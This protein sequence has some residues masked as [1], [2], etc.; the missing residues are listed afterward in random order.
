MLGFGSWLTGFLWVCNLQISNKSVPQT[1]NRI[2]RSLSSTRIEFQSCIEIACSLALNSYCLPLVFSFSDSLLTFLSPRVF[3]TQMNKKPS[4]HDESLIFLFLMFTVD[5]Q[6]SAV[7]EV[8]GNICYWRCVNFA[9]S[10]SL[11]SVGRTPSL[12]LAISLD[13][14]ILRVW[15]LF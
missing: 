3:F 6:N 10:L 4:L 5:C 14:D 9:K 12:T 2:D 8:V 13:F 11:D 15:V 1:L 7:D